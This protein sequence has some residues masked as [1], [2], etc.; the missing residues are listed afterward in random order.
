VAWLS[1]E[2]DRRVEAGLRSVILLSCVARRV[3]EARLVVPACDGT[4]LGVPHSSCNASLT[5]NSSVLVPLTALCLLFAIVSLA[6]CRSIRADR[7]T[8][9]A[10]PSLPRL[11]REVD[12][13]TRVLRL[14]PGQLRRMTF[15]A[16]KEIPLPIVLE[17]NGQV[18]FDDRRVATIISRVAGRF[19]DIR[20]SQWD[21]VGKGEP[22]VLLYSPDFMTAEAEYLASHPRPGNAQGVPPE[23]GGFMASLEVAAKRKLELLGMN[24]ADIAAIRQPSSSVW[25]RAPI[26]GVVVEKKAVRGAQVNPGDALF[27]VATLDQVWITADIYE[28]DLARVRVGEAIQALT[29]AYPA[30]VFSG[31]IDRISP[32]IDPTTHTLQL[33]CQITNRG[34]KLRPQMLARI[35]IVT[36]PGSAL[37][38]DERALVFDTDRYFA[39]VLSPGE[40]IV[41]REV[42]IRSWNE[43]GYARVV[44]GLRPGDRVVAAESLE[45]D[46]L[47]DEA[48]VQDPGVP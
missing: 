12:G 28:D 5:R 45:V 47:W 26:S 35:R 18:T 2:K 23:L 14:A 21:T 19:E 22:I 24:D 41:R 44:S 33:R 34:L 29:T 27:S 13:G 8:V 46:Y 15:A 7:A 17:A 16:V 4:R 36:K 39:F 30:E 43:R 42:S 20:V 40:V 3:C 38:V 1:S 37:V 31:V 9:D 32:S 25:M 6:G 48:G 11:E 10:G